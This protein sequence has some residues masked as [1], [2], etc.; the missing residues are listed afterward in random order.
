MPDPILIPQPPTVPGL[1]FR[2]FRGAADYPAIARVLAESDNADGI[3]RQVTAEQ[4]AAAYQRMSNCD[5]YQDLILAEA[6]GKVVGYGRGWWEESTTGWLYGLGGFL[7]PEWRR[8]GIGT[9]MLQWLEIRLRQVAAEHSIEGTSFFQ[10]DVKENQIGKQRLLE[11]A[12]YQA[13]RYFYEMVRPDLEQIQEWPLPEGVEVR[14]VRPEH[15]PAIWQSA[16]ETGQEEWGYTPPT[17]EDYQEWLHSPHFQPHLWQVAWDPLAERIVGQVLTYIDE[18]QN[19]QMGRRRGYTE[20]IGV[21]RAWRRH[22]LARALIARSLQAQKAAGMTESALIVDSE[23]QSN[24]TRLYESCGFQVVSRSAVYRKAL[25][26][27]S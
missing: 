14:P 2:H 13:V 22:G 24:A 4:I 5:P 23:S 17:E 12:G 15:Y 21:D 25:R 20:G 19:R 9:A 8:K 7:V 10:V 1:I 27:S 16:T 3:E 6:A 11:N 26:Q 18:N